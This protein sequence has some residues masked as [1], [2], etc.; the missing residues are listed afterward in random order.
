MLEECVPRREI[1]EA[2]TLKGEW[3]MGFR[4]VRRISPSFVL[5]KEA[6]FGTSTMFTMITKVLL[7]GTRRRV[8]TRECTEKNTRSVFMRARLWQFFR[9]DNSTR[10]KHCPSFVVSLSCGTGDGT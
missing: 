5:G 3:R 7:H 9:C 10:T 4:L 8:K 1:G 2:E 6:M